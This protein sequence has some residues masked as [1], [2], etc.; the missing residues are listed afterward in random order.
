MHMAHTFLMNSMRADDSSHEQFVVKDNMLP[1]ICLEQTMVS[2]SA[3]MYGAVQLT[4]SDH[5]SKTIGNFQGG[6]DLGA[7]RG[8]FG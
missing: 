1:M 4:C 7:F 5:G 8:V 2:S 3:L 6:E